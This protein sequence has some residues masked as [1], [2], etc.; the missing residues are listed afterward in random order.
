MEGVQ[1]W[2]FI[3][4]AFAIGFLLGRGTVLRTSGPPSHIPDAEALEKVRS[5]MEDGDKIAAIKKYRELTGAG[6]ADAKSAVETLRS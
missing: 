2:M 5:L 3:G 6:L 4:G 1:G